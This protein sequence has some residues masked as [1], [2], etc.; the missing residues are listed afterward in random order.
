RWENARTACCAK[1]SNICPAKLR[2]KLR[3]SCASTMPRRKSSNARGRKFRRNLPRVPPEQ[4][5]RDAARR[6]ARRAHSPLRPHPLC[7]LHAR[8]PV[9]SGVRLLQQNGI[10]AA[11]RLLHQ[12]GRASDFWQAACAQICRDVGAARTAERVFARSEERRVGKECGWWL[13]T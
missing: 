3:I 7:R 12:C 11:R 5:A 4:K 10:A 13:G 2:T 1:S 9:P 8:M 6:I